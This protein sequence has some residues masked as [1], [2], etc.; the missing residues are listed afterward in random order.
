L[1]GIVDSVKKVTDI[2]AEIAAASQEQSSGIDQVNRAVMQMDE[3]TQ[4]NAALVEEASAAARAMQE[5]ANEL[6]Q[7]MTF[8]RVDKTERT[9]PEAAPPK[10]VAETAVPPRRQVAA[11]PDVMRPAMA[12]EWTEF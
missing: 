9:T 5:Q 12:G 11:R 3:V 2:V 10:R 6:R 4:Q 8:F 1:T 7:Q